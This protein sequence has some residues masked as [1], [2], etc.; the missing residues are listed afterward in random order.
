MK[1]KIEYVINYENKNVF[2][3][4]KIKKNAVLIMKIK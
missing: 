4:V 3:I 2:F 1:I